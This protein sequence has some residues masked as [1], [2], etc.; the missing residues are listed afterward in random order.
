MRSILA[1]ISALLISVSAGYASDAQ[2]GQ[3]N[4]QMN[5]QMQGQMQGMGQMPHTMMMS[6]RA[7]M[8]TEP[9]QGAFGTI[10][11]IVA[12]LRADAKTDWSKVDIGR[13]RRHLVDM[14]LLTIDSDVAISE[15]GDE[16]LFNVTGSGRTLQAI[17]T[18]VPAHSIELNKFPQFSAT[19]EKTD[20]G[21][22]LRISGLKPEKKT[23]VLALGFF[24][25]MVTG[26][27]HQQH[28]LAV[29]RGGM[30]NH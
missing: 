19:A 2:T 26:A 23:E 7:Q 1:V 20:N 21:V 9:G 3:T 24:G 4:G 22:V 10:A 6:G 28:H 25:M 27:H 17:Q 18:M 16:V 11:E 14:N 5:G 29:A 30:P 8:P 15:K 13:L 12:I